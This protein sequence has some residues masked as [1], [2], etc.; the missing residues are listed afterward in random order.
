VCSSIQVIII[1]SGITS[2]G[3]VGGTNCKGGELVITV[4]AA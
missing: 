3:S 2:M 1:L 4:A